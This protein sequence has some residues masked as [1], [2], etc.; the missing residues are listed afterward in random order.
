MIKPFRFIS[1][2][3][4]LILVAPA[5]AADPRGTVLTERLASRVLEDN[6]IGLDVNRTVKVYL[7]PSYQRSGKRFPV[8]Y[9]LHNTWWSPDQMFADGNLVRLLERGFAGG[10]GEFI[11]VAADYSTVNTGSI[12]ESSPV[13]GRWLEFTVDEL[14]PFIDRRFRTLADRNSRAV[15]GDFFGG[16]GA[17]KFAMSHADVFGVAYALNPV[18]AGS[19]DIPL[20]GLQIDWRKIHAAR[21]FAELGEDGR[22]RLFVAISQAFLPNPDRPPF[23]C[24]F[25]MEPE[26]DSFRFDAGN[27]RRMQKLFH[28]D[29]TLDES[30]ANLRSMRGL[31]FDWGR[32][33]P[34]QA[35]VVSNREFSRKLEDLG[36]EHEAEEYRG[37]P[38]NRTW[39][40]DGRFATRVLPFLARHLVY[41]E[42]KVR[43]SRHR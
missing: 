5:D 33:D 8:L 40:E 27:A 34:S 31:A 4:A 22:T 10:I 3:L 2:L 43:T 19:G 15:V 30:A 37:D 13:S 12:Y 41:E 26:G 23:Y 16:R 1:V 35:H 32:F 42:S 20:Q 39:T 24:D 36:I 18:A 11:L 7:P 14:V 9:Y 21:S 29:E 17:L 6:R 25:F 28:L 38:W